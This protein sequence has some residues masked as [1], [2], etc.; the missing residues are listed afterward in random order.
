MK[1]R[2][3]AL[4]LAAL[5]VTMSI[6]TVSTAQS[7]G[8]MDDVDCSGYTFEDLFEYNNAEFKFKVLD[9]WASS[10]LCLLTA[11]VNESRAAVVRD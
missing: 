3:S 7:S 11:W 10:D 9:D 8:G 4:L 6:T 2:V 1:G 5:M